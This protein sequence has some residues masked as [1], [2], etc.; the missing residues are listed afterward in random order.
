VTAALKAATLPQ[1]IR[2]LREQTGFDIQ[3][4]ELREG[5]AEPKRH[6]FTWKE[7]PLKEALRQVGALA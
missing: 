7:A 6:S 5:E 4:V 1:A 2:D 3:Y